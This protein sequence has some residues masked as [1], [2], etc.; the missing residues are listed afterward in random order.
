MPTT[1]PVVLI[2]DNDRAVSS[3]LTEV[4]VR[5]GLQVRHAYDGEDARTQA[6]MAGID[7]LVCDL[8]MPKLSGLDV[9]EALLGVPCPPQAIVISGYLDGAVMARLG[10]LPHVRE[11]MRKPF[12][13]LA[14]AETVRRIA[15][16]GRAP[17][18]EAAALP[19]PQAQL[20]SAE[21]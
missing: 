5:T 13:L 6:R 4:L 8:D 18:V 1:D 7:V 17:I 20:G 10:A 2:A 19:V 11:V 14:F 16:A 3:L 21:Q 12:D 15:F 9:L